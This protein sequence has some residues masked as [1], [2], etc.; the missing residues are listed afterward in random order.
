LKFLIDECLST[1]LVS[2]AKAR[3]FGQST[4]AAWRGL[5]SVRD[6]KLVLLAVEQS[7]ILVTRNARHFAREL[8]KL[9]IHLGAVFL[10]GPNH[11]MRPAGQVAL[12]TIALDEIGSEEPINQ[13]IEVVASGT[14]GARLRRYEMV[15]RVPP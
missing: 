4:H 1:A 2:A 8:A 5:S 13:V 10:T 6:W 14:V 9:E 12:F 7:F 11:R 15:A 3:G